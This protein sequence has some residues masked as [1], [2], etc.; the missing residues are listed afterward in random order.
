MSSKRTIKDCNEGNYNI[1]EVDGTEYLVGCS[2][3]PHNNDVTNWIQCTDDDCEVWYCEAYIKTTFNLLDDDLET[4]RNDPDSFKC[5][6][7]GLLQI[8]FKNLGDKQSSHYNLRK[9]TKQSFEIPDLETEDEDDELEEEDDDLD[10]SAM[11]LQKFND[12]NIKADKKK[13]ASRVRAKKKQSKPAPKKGKK[14][15]KK[16]ADD[17]KKKN[18]SYVNIFLL[19]YCCAI[20]LNHIHVYRTNGYHS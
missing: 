20:I 1:E 10:Y 6:D 17:K 14:R 12:I 9:R 7:H 8:D 11:T 5:I 19:F 13:L 16:E 3:A 4:L 2:C 18:R 15:K